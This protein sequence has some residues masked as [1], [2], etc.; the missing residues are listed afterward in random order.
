M[1][2]GMTIIP[3]KVILHFTKHIV[4]VKRKSGQQVQAIRFTKKSLKFSPNS[5]GHVAMTNFRPALQ[6]S[7]TLNISFVVVHCDHAQVGTFPC[8]QSK[9]KLPIIASNTVQSNTIFL[10]LFVA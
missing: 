2:V 3:V 7:F 8:G 5:V 6:Y 10:F 9:L 1:I 4:S